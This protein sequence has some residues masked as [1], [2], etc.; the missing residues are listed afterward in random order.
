MTTN[1]P[2]RHHYIPQFIL[3][4]FCDDQGF[5]SYLDKESGRILQ[6]EPKDIF[7]SR[8]LYRDEVNYPEDRM[9]IENAF[10]AYESEISKLINERILKEKDVIISLDENESLKLF[11]ALMGFRSKRVGDKFSIKN[12]DG[13]DIIHKLYEKNG[14]L[15]DFWKRNLGHLVNCRSFI[16]VN[17]RP[18]IDEA[19]K[20]FMLRD[21]FGY[22][23]KHFA[24]IE[25]DE[26]SGFVIGDAYPTVIYGVLPNGI[27]EELYSIIPLSPDKALLLICKEADYAPADAGRIRPLLLRPPCNIDGTHIKIRTKK[28]FPEE[29]KFLNESIFSASESGVAF[30]NDQLDR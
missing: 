5:L 25:S 11:F 23:G 6:K 13:S 20:I 22:F 18:D 26:S 16:Q 14:D 19:I 15:T 27:R 1:E 2:V 10:S 30:R 29:V 9:K 7:V 8:N 21:T 28:L 24:L 17:D 3:R 4:K 12:S